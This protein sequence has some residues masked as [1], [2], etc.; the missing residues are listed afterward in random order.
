VARPEGLDHA[1]PERSEGRH[2]LETSG[3]SQAALRL[4]APGR[5]RTFDPRLRRPRSQPGRGFIVYRLQRCPRVLPTRLRE[6][7]P[8]PPEDLLGHLGTHTVGS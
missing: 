2:D 7:T 3:S 5:T 1:R 4:G 6:A 8:T